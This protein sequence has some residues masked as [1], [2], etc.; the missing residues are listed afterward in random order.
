M[1]KKKKKDALPPYAGL[2]TKVVCLTSL[3]CH[4]NANVKACWLAAMENE[5]M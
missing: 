2:K 1:C 3:S 4:E 5:N